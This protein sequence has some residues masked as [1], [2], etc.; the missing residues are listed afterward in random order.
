MVF[1]VRVLLD[2]ERWGFVV[3][4]FAAD[5][6]L[7][8]HPLR[9]TLETFVFVAI[10]KFGDLFCYAA[11]SRVSRFWHGQ[12]SSSLE[13]FLEFRRSQVCDRSDACQ[14]CAAYGAG[15]DFAAPCHFCECVTCEDCVAVA[16]F[17]VQPRRL[18][19]WVC[20]GCGTEEVFQ[21]VES[22]KGGFCDEAGFRIHRVLAD[23]NFGFFPNGVTP[24]RAKRD[25]QAFKNEQ[26]GQALTRSFPVYGGPSTE[27]LILEAKREAAALQARQHSLAGTS[28]AVSASDSQ[29]ELD[30]LDDDKAADNRDSDVDFEPDWDGT[31]DQDS[32]ATVWAPSNSAA[33]RDPTVP[34][35]KNPWHREASGNEAANPGSAP[36][37]LSVSPIRACADC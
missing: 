17:V 16:A 24:L 33:V 23:Y 22:L 20:L 2:M 28:E 12:F 34:A 32:T 8:W 27:T 18:K 26:I 1:A 30:A 19:M 5:G 29:M 31:A 36:V 11:L 3:A 13:C 7:H 10:S 37:H 21:S 15:S 4:R 14:Y 35:Q 6:V 9:P 25:M